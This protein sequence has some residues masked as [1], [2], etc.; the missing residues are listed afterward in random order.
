[1]KKSRLLREMRG[2]KAK[3]K[4]DKKFL[5]DYG[6]HLLSQG[7][8]ENQDIHISFSGQFL[9]AH[10]KPDEWQLSAI[11]DNSFCMSLLMDN[12]TGERIKKDVPHS[13]MLKARVSPDDSF[14]DRMNNKVIPLRLLELLEC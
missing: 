3:P 14:C 6:E 5:P 1:M 9:L 11:I 10:D 2:Q 4:P 12:E 8:T 13:M 7:L